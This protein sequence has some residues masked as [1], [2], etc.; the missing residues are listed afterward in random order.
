MNEYSRAEPSES[1]PPIVWSDYYKIRNR[2]SVENVR[3]A[4]IRRGMSVS[5][6]IKRIFQLTLQ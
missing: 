3:K 4:L 1:E 5:V 2:T 6:M